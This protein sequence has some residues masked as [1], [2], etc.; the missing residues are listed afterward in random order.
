MSN[1]LPEG[2]T[3]IKLACCGTLWYMSSELKNL[4]LKDDEDDPKMLLEPC[5]S[6]IYSLGVSL[7]HLLFSF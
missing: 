6:D 5:K 4:I 1:K 3:Q 2:K 7:M